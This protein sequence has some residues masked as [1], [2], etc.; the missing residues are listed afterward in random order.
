MKAKYTRKSAVALGY[1]PAEADAPRVIAK[2]KGRIAEKIL[3]QAKEHGVPIQED[4]SLVE[5]LATLELNEQIPVELYQVVAEIL[6]FV[7]ETDRRSE[8][9]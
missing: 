6:A 9:R 5:V 2:G 4:P 8:C 3:E 7:Y 1:N